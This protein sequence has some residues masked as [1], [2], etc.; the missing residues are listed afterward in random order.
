MMILSCA[1]ACAASGKKRVLLVVKTCDRKLSLVLRT[2]FGRSGK[3]E[4]WTQFAK[5]T[6]FRATKL[7]RL[8]GLSLRTLERKFRR[9]LRRGPQGWLYERRLIGVRLMLL[10]GYSVREVARKLGFKH[11]SHL[12]Q[13]FRREFQQTPLEFVTHSRWR[14]G[15]FPKRRSAAVP[16]R[17]HSRTGRFSPISTQPREQ[18]YRAGAVDASS[19][20]AKRK[21]PEVRRIPAAS[22]LAPPRR[23]LDVGPLTA[24]EKEVLGLQA[25]GLSYKMIADQLHISEHTV[26]NELYS[27]RQKLGAHNA[28]EAINEIAGASGPG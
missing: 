12:C 22:K 7:A 4:H 14:K 19:E 20:R 10:A 3:L 24:R 5:L 6:G 13:Q 2:V 26:N 15:S 11:E 25:E 9:E 28:I 16:G 17:G 21:R 1:A 23:P 8:F 27:I 18:K